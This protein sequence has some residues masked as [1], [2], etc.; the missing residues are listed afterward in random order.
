M[1][2][3]WIIPDGYGVVIAC[4]LLGLKIRE[5]ISGSD[6]FSEINYKLNKRIDCNCVFLGSTKKH[7]N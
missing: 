7:L 1:H 2:S 6:I 5:R 4:K 3:N